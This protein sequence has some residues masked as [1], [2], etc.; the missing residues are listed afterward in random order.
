MSKRQLSGGRANINV[1]VS[2]KRTMGGDSEGVC[3]LVPEG[4][5][6]PEATGA[7]RKWD[8]M[9]AGIVLVGITTKGDVSTR[10]GTQT[11]KVLFH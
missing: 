10:S 9:S 5:W 6:G 7:P 2:P 11:K 4:R 1:I 3:A 8:E